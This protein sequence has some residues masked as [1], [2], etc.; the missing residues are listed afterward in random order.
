MVVPSP[1]HVTFI[2]AAAVLLTQ[3][4]QQVHMLR[5]PDS[6]PGLQDL[7]LDV[8]FIDDSFHS[9]NLG[10]PNLQGRKQKG[11]PDTTGGA[12]NQSSSGRTHLKT[13]TF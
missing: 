1:G 12:K 10:D 8:V 3:R 5:V 7:R 6:H 2:L 4:P 9:W 13:E 11:N